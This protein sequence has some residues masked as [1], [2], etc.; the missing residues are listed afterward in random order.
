MIPLSLSI[1]RQSLLTAAASA[2]AFAHVQCKNALTASSPPCAANPA[3]PQCCRVP[4]LCSA[5]STRPRRAL[6]AGE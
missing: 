3:V 6:M 1:S 2:R 5:F 4:S